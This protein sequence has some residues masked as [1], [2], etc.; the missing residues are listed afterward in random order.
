MADLERVQITGKVVKPNGDNFLNSVVRFTMSGFDTDAPEGVTVV[1]APID[2]EIDDNSEIDDLLWPNPDG[3]RS[4]FYRVAVVVRNADAAETVYNLATISVP[5]SGGPYDLN[6]LFGVAPPEGATLEEYIASLAAAVAS[7]EAAAADAT[8]SADAAAVSAAN[9]AAAAGSLGE[10]FIGRAAFLAAT[11]SVD[12]NKASYIEGGEVVSFVYD[13]AGVAATTS[14][15]RTWSPDGVSTPE[16]YGTDDN[17]AVPAFAAD[18]GGRVGDLKQS[19]VYSLTNKVFF[20]D[21]DWTLNANGATLDYSG[22]SNADGDTAGALVSIAGAVDA[23]VSLTSITE[24]TDAFGQIVTTVVSS[25]PHGLSVGDDVFLSSD[26]VIDAGHDL[27]QET[28]GQY[29]RVDTVTSTTGFTANQPLFEALTTNPVMTRVDWAENCHIKG[30]LTIKGPG[31]RPTAIGYSGLSLTYA[32]DC[33]IDELVTDGVDYQALSRDMCVRVNAGQLT[34]KFAPKGSTNTQNQYG[35][36]CK[37]GSTDCQTGGIL[38]Y[39][40]KHIFDWTRNT[41]PGI[42]RNCVVGPIVAYDTWDA[43]VATHGNC[44]DLVFSTVKAIN[45]LYAFGTRVPGIRVDDIYGENCYEVLKLTDDARDMSIGSVR[46]KNCSFIVRAQDPTWIGSIEGRNINIG[47]VEADG[48]LQNTIRLDYSDIPVLTEASAAVV[49]GGANTITLD[50]FTFTNYNYSG[51]LVGS[52]IIMDYDGAGGGSEQ[53]RVITGHVWN[54]TTNVLTTSNWTNAPTVAATYKIRSFVDDINIGPVISKNCAGADIYVEG[55]LRR[56]TIGDMDVISDGVNAAAA[57]FVTGTADS[58]PERVRFGR[59]RNHNKGLAAVSGF[60]VDVTFEVDASSDTVLKTG[61]TMTGPLILSGEP[62]DDLGATT[63]AYVDERTEDFGTRAQA[64]A[65][66]A[67][68]PTTDVKIIQVANMS[69]RNSSGATAIADMP[70][71]LPN[72]TATPDHFKTNG[73]GVNMSDAIQA[74]ADFEGD[75][76]TI[77]FRSAEYIFDADGVGT[78]E[79][80]AVILTA[81]HS[82]LTFKGESGTVLKPASNR[83]EM[84]AHDGA[85]NIT[86]DGLLFD[87]SANGPLQYQVKVA[88]TAP[89]LGIAGN[90]NGANCGYRQYSGPSLTVRNCE[91][92]GFT[93]AVRYFGDATD[94]QVLS[95]DLVVDNVKFS[96]CAFGVLA[97]QPEHIMM[98]NIIDVDCFQSLNGN[99]TD[100]SETDLTVTSND[101]G[102]ALYVSDRSGAFPKTV[103]IDTVASTNAESTSIRVRK[104]ETVSITNTTHNNCERFVNVENA[105]NATV[106]NVSGNMVTTTFANQSAIQIVDCENYNVSNFS[107][108]L[109]DADGWAVRAN[110]RDGGFAERNEN[111]RISNGVITAN[112]SAAAGKASIL[113]SQQ[114][115]TTVEDIQLRHNGLVVSDNGVVDFVDSDRCTAKNISKLTPDG[116]DD[117]KLVNVRAGCT[118]T[119]VKWSE[120]DLDQVPNAD[121]VDD[122]GTDTRIFRDGILSGTFTPTVEF[123]TNGDFVP[124]YN[125]AATYGTWRKAGG[126]VTVDLSVA[127]DTNAYTT[128][129]GDLVIPLTFAAKSGLAPRYGGYLS[130]HQKIDTGSTIVD[131]TP[132]VADGASQIK[133]RQNSD[134]GNGNDIGTGNI[135]A[136]TTG[137]TLT[138]S[139]TYPY[140]E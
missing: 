130:F 115:G 20:A 65:W 13:A 70:D 52:Q 26:D 139:I 126:Y 114:Y 89:D 3:V 71:W 95:G 131:L 8:A 49:S 91:F 79:G 2:F 23:A 123:T 34:F 45:C 6:E 105:S 66:V 69:F 140:A 107:I 127:F 15:G 61:S 50:P 100:G 108:D 51:A 86:L 136:S 118:N 137:F 75:N 112:Y 124:A 72:G 53:T 98:T 99:N 113:I 57:V 74:A 85:E 63:K 31:R 78:S 81:A 38:G 12:V 122:G 40:G 64:V 96:G 54:G 129:S 103:T 33:S 134:A 90:G 11:I 87:N 73:V 125:A 21:G 55:N 59:L 30:K 88:S 47:R 80:A 5:S 14:D 104:G 106:S 29:V 62:T 32:R 28:R 82:N 46:A 76:G 119:T 121:T 10:V 116:V 92:R 109:T 17:V 41:N 16:H 44:R 43:A 77:E 68:N 9:A 102:H 42:G 135:P 24:V 25:T 48:V 67:A 138:L 60:A 133:L 37:N 128:S 39:G 93:E 97:N 27:T 18:L 4:T 22:K 19:K 120:A 117:T 7:S 132:L 36:T 58:Y 111:G 101:P 110:E 83:I 35:D 84:F 1:N 94:N 56:L